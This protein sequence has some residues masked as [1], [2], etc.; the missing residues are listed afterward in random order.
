MP[1]IL[2]A[3]SECRFHEE[4]E[5]ERPTGKNRCPQCGW[6]TITACPVPE[7]KALITKPHQRYCEACGQMLK[8][9]GSPYRQAFAEMD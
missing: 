3:N 5:G 9:K 2:C 8:L 6:E 7:C 1:Y 4:F